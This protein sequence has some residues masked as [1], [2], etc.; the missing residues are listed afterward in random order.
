MPR[1]RKITFGKVRS[2]GTRGLARGR[3]AR[4]LDCFG[5]HSRGWTGGRV[6]ALLGVEG[7]AVGASVWLRCAGGLSLTFELG[8]APEALCA[9]WVALDR[10]EPRARVVNGLAI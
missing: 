3:N 8:P 1:P 10:L 2:E 4:R 7:A 6:D 9:C 5:P